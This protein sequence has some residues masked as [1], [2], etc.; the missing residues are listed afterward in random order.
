MPDEPE[1]SESNWNF[2]RVPEAELI[3][4]SYWEYA[5]ESA[6]IRAAYDPDEVTFFPPFSAAPAYSG[7]PYAGRRLDR[8][9]GDF[10]FQIWE[11]ALP[12][13]LTHDRASQALRPRTP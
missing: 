13:K 2:V 10:I 7:S 3:A 11:Q 8:A 5:R 1:L 4:C 12:V 6:R 9:R